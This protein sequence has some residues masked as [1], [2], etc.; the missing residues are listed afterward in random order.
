MLTGKCPVCGNIKV[1]LVDNFYKTKKVLKVHKRKG[2]KATGQRHCY[3]SG[4]EPV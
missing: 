4:K 1:G 2:T 3:G